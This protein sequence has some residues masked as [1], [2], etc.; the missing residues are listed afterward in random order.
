MRFRLERDGGAA[1]GE[2][3]VFLLPGK[4]TL[5]KQ[6]LCIWRGHSLH[7][8]AAFSAIL[9]DALYRSTSASSK[10]EGK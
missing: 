9:K 10:E 8:E 2:T 6:K 7:D 1:Y 4:Y 5:A 3:R